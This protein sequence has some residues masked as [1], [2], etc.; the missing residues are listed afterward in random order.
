MISSEIDEYDSKVSEFNDS[1][2]LQFPSI[3]KFHNTPIATCLLAL[4]SSLNMRKIANPDLKLFAEHELDLRVGIG[5]DLLVKLRSYISIGTIN[6]RFSQKNTISTKEKEKERGRNKLNTAKI[7]KVFKQYNGNWEKIQALVKKLDL[8]A[9]VETAKVENLSRLDKRD[10]QFFS[11]WVDNDGELRPGISTDNIPWI[12]QLQGRDRDLSASAQI[13]HWEINC[14][15]FI[16]L[17]CDQ[18][19]SYLKH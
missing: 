10:I 15:L 1:V 13:R 9:N 18:I 8:G 14:Q 7:D 6:Y 2:Y 11:A 5:H 3:T 17:I 19:L 4:P 12:W 16:L